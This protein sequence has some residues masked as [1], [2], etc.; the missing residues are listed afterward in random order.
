MRQQEKWHNAESVN[1]SSS[2][3]PLK[4]LQLVREDGTCELSLDNREILPRFECSSLSGHV[5]ILWL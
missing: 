4:M 1:D 3:Q 2:F 5:E